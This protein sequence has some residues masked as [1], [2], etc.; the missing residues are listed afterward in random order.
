MSD[1][2]D[3]SLCRKCL[4]NVNEREKIIAG[5][6]QHFIANLN[7]LL[8]REPRKPVDICD[9][10][11]AGGGAQGIVLGDG[12]DNVALQRFIVRA[13]V[14]QIGCRTVVRCQ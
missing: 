7:G 2:A 14:L 5:R 1:D 6:V 4:Q 10:T 12:G 11:I 9:L 3:G 8:L 13:E